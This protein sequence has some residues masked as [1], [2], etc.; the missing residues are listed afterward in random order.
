MLNAPSHGGNTRTV[1]AQP[2]S[3]CSSQ[4]SGGERQKQGHYR[5]IT[6]LWGGWLRRRGNS[7]E[8]TT[9]CG[10]RTE[11]GMSTGEEFTEDKYVAGCCE[12]CAQLT[13]MLH[14]R[15]RIGG[16]RAPGSLRRRGSCG[17]LGQQQQNQQVV[18]AVRART[19]FGIWNPPSQAWVQFFPES[20][21]FSAWLLI[22]VTQSPTSR[23]SDFI[24]LRWGPGISIF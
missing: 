12:M 13:A 3:L 7:Q 6:N 9:H 2:Q 24:G 23:D 16:D 1:Q 17:I 8:G 21:W 22:T 4:L 20:V 14:F 18:V 10:G 5:E 19:S 11:R 15:G